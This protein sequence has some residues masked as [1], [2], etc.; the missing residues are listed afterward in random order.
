MRATSFAMFALLLSLA[1]SC[2][3]AQ[4]ADLD[5][6]ITA[7]LIIVWPS[8]TAGV[9]VP[10]LA[11]NGMAGD[12]GIRAVQAHLNNSNIAAQ[13]IVTNSF[14][15]PITW[16]HEVDADNPGGG[17]Q[18]IVVATGGSFAGEDWSG[19]LRTGIQT[20]LR[21]RP[22]ATPRR[23]IHMAATAGRSLTVTTVT[24]KPMAA[25]DLGVVMGVVLLRFQA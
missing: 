2:I 25:T 12:V 6:G 17:N 4:Q 10:C 20:V 16:G 3:H 13:V 15:V 5:N 1:A 18:E 8:G 11:G 19:R 24:Q 21:I 9:G 23:P 14:A 22:E 7:N